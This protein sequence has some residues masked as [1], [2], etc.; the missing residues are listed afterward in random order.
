MRCLKSREAGLNAAQNLKTL[1]VSLA[2]I[3]AAR[4]RI[5]GQV[6][7][8]PFLNAPQLSKQFG[9]DIWIKYENMQATNSFKERGALNKLLQLNDKE[10]KQGVIAVSAGN[11]A[12]AVAYHAAR[13][14]IPA[15]IVMPTTT[16]GVKVEATERY[17]AKVVLSGET[18]AESEIRLFELQAKHNL[19]LIHPYDDAA[20][21][22]GQGTIGLEMLKSER[23][24]DCII[25]PVGGGGLASGIAIAAKSLKPSIKIITVESEF[26]PSLWCKLHD[27]PFKQPTAG[28]LAEGIAVKNIGKLTYQILKSLSDEL[29]LVSEN[30]IEWAINAYLETLKTLA[31]GAGAAGLAA[32]PQIKDKLK[33]KKV[34]IILCGGNI[35]PRM[36]ATIMVR[37]LEREEK[38]VA[39]RI[40][41][42]DRPGTLGRITTLLGELGANILEVDHR[43]LFLNVSAKGAYL[44]IT[45]EVRGPAHAKTVLEKLRAAGHDITRLASGEA[46]F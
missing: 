36:A 9:A 18:I 2:D 30:D 28:T 8:T 6:L 32:L 45:V 23:D 10:K 37:A 15:T 38:I 11:H 29:L 7:A 40:A 1:P 4:A 35:D 22:A 26:Y 16:P 3:E 42:T 25:I 20:I 41:I 34:G 24:L 14:K 44:D 17:G 12:Q 31:E 46:G 27:K 21:I 39:F 33:G 19:V 13:L 43:R 5:S